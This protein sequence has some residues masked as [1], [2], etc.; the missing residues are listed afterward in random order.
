MGCF[1]HIF[2]CRAQPKFRLAAQCASDTSPCPP[3]PLRPSKSAGIGARHASQTLLRPMAPLRNFRVA[4][5]FL[6]PASPLRHSGPD[7]ESPKRSATKTPFYALRRGRPPIHEPG[8]ATF[9][10]SQGRKRARPFPETGV[11]SMQQNESSSN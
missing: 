11:T 7:P 5:I 6:I 4:C 8:S 10:A 9:Q 2:P 1:T 3:S